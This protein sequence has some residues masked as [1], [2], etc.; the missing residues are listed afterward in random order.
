VCQ[1]QPAP[2]V[3][4][5][6]LGVDI[7]LL[8][9]TGDALQDCYRMIADQIAVREALQRIERKVDALKCS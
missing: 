1:Q 4:G 3:Q 2:E 8:R 5:D 7:E 9:A 6:A